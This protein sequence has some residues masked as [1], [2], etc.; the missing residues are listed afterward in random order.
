MYVLAS[1]V[2]SLSPPVTSLAL[3]Q[4]PGSLV[5]LS[6]RLQLLLSVQCQ[7]QCWFDS[8]DLH[9]AVRGLATHITFCRASRDQTAGIYFSVWQRPVALSFQYGHVLCPEIKCN[10]SAEMKTDSLFVYE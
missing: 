8:A 3:V 10:G 9:S 1:S 4:E 2:F 7:A 6:D 5:S